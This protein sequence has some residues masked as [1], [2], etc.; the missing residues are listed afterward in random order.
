MLTLHIP[1]AALPQPKR[2]E[3]SAGQQRQQAA[4]GGG[5]QS[6][7]SQRQAEMAAQTR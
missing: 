6:D 7:A 3:I 5:R 2:I 1:K 4:V